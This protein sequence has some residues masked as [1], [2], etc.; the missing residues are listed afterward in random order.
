MF[1][2]AAIGTSSPRPATRRGEGGDLNHR[3]AGTDQ[4]VSPDTSW[5]PGQDPAVGDRLERVVE[6]LSLA[7]CGDMADPDDPFTARVDYTLADRLLAD[8]ATSHQAGFA[9]RTG[10][11]RPQL[12]LVGA[13]AAEHVGAGTMTNPNAPPDDRPIAA[14]GSWDIS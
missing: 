4:P 1:G 7:S 11:V 13:H 9:P 14:A 2:T 10:T 5:K 3:S 8:P 6:V 12:P